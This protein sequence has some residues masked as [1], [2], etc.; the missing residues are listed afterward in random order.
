MRKHSALCDIARC[1]SPSVVCLRLSVRLFVSAEAME[2]IKLLHSVFCTKQT[3]WWNSSG[4]PTAGKGR[5]VNYSQHLVVSETTRDGEIITR[6]LIRSHVIYL[7]P[8]RLTLSYIRPLLMC[9]TVPVF[10]RLLHIWHGW[11]YQLSADRLPQIHTESRDP[12]TTAELLVTA[13]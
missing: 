11:L 5:I 9:E 1:L 3:C 4:P 8:F 7:V 10:W 13:T 2:S 6:T 12:S